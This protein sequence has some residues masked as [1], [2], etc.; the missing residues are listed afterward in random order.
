MYC[1]Y[2]SRKM[3]PFKMLSCLGFLDMIERERC[4]FSDAAVVSERFSDKN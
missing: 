2:Y 3:L 4:A 1:Y